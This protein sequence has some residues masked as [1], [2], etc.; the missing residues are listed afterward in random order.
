MNVVVKQPASIASRQN[1][2][3]LLSTVS[4]QYQAT[5]G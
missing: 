4:S 2:T 3:Y 1:T 5:V